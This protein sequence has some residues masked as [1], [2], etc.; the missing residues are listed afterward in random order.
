MPLKPQTYALTAIAYQRHR[1]EQSGAEGL[2]G[3]SHLHT[4]TAYAVR[5][6]PLPKI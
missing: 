5:M 4:A 1:V 3:V 2:G 6:D